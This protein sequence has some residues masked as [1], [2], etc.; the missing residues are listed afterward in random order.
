MTL[1]LKNIALCVLTVIAVFFYIKDRIRDRQHEIDMAKIEFMDKNLN[2]LVD[3]A[4]PLL[5]D[6]SRTKDGIRVKRAFVPPEGTIR[7]KVLQEPDKGSFK[8]K[9]E[10]KNK[11][12]TFRPGLGVAYDGGKL[13]LIAS[14]KLFYWGRYGGILNVNQSALGVGVSRFIDD[15]VPYWHPRNVELFIAYGFLSF[16]PNTD[17]STK[18]QI[19]FRVTL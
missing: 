15:L 4:G 8:V 18:L 2:R 13:R 11:G 19:G 14:S 16:R 12:I 5:A 17:N 3:I 10:V 7:V 9:T 6:K 1:S